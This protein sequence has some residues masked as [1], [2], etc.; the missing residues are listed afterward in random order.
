MIKSLIFII[1]LLLIKITQTETSKYDASNA[2]NVKKDN[3][4]C[5]KC[6]NYEYK[7]INEDTRLFWYG[8]DLKTNE[9]IWMCSRNSKQESNALKYNIK[10]SCNNNQICLYD[11]KDYYPLKYDCTVNEDIKTYYVNYIGN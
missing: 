3:F 2:I 8:Y 9:P 6:G 7:S 1:N 11:F 5:L 4:I 10:F